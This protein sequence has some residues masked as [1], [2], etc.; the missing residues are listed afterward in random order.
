MFKKK[1]FALGLALALSFNMVPANIPIIGNA[2]TVEAKTLS[3]KQIKKSL[4]ASAPKSTI[5]IPEFDG[6][7]LSIELNDG[8]PFFSNKCLTKKSIEYYSPLD[9]LGRVGTTFAVISK[10]TMP[11]TERGSI[12]HIKPTG[13]HQNKYPGLV[14]TNPAYALNRT[15]CIG[16]WAVG[17][18]SNIEQ[19]LISGTRTCNEEMLKYEVKIADYLDDNP[20]KHVLYRVTPIFR[21]QNLFADGVVMEAMSV[22]DKG[23]SI[24]LCT[25]CYNVIPGVTFDY[26]T[27][28]NWLSSDSSK[29]NK[30]SAAASDKSNISGSGGNTEFTYVVNTNTKKFHYPDCKSVSDMKA[31]NK[32]ISHE[33]RD[34]LIEQGYSPCGNCKP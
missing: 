11:T 28:E 32:L 1:I 13:W 21:D 7:N 20:T 3:V 23:K 15:H 16:F 18:S 25:F 30:D 2:V 6:D 22:E 8:N 9:K 19:N 33:S 4:K 27:G 29:A 12:G 5:S 17:S 14:S 10:S 34:A 26:K 31:K 24:K